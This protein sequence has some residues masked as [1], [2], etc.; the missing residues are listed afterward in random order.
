MSSSIPEG[1]KYN[2]YIYIYILCNTVR[3]N[4]YVS[5]TI[6]HFPLQVFVFM[7]VTLL[8]PVPVARA[9]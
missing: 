5:I 8:E 1:L 4:L 2:I 9:V 7:D 3:H 6:V